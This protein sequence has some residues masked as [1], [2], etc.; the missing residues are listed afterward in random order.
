MNLVVVVA[1][2]DAAAL[3]WIRLDLPQ[4]FDRFPQRSRHN[5]Q[6]LD[7]QEFIGTAAGFFFLVNTSKIPVFIGLDMITTATVGFDLLLLP[8]VVLGAVAGFYLLPK[9]PQQACNAIVLFLAG[10]AAVCMMT[11]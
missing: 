3:L 11:L 4:A 9:I 1:G 6:R 2:F 8:M 5:N 10:A 7:K